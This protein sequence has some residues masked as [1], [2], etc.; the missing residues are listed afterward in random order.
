MTPERKYFNE[1][2][3][4]RFIR[5]FVQTGDLV[6]DVG[7]P[8]DGWGYRE[9]FREARYK[10][11]DRNKFLQPDI[12]DDIEDTKLEESS[13]DC[14][15]CFG[16]WEQCANPFKLVKGLQKILK[17]GGFGLFGIMSIGVP[18]IQDWDLCRFTPQGVE[19]L[20]K[21]FRVADFDVVNRG[22]IPSYVFVVVVKE[23]GV[24]E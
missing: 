10:T 13:I 20:L 2:V 15:V 24:T 3:L 6:V 19:R 4:P 9:M 1:V 5:D 12:W 11:L 8:N 18:L 17:V 21:D 14:I 22:E 7:K 23:K 16:V